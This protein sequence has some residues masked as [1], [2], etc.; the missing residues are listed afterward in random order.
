[1]LLT[2]RISPRLMDALMLLAGFD[3]QKTDEPKS[4][5]DPHNLFEAVYEDR[6]EGDFSDR[7][8]PRS[9]HNWL[10]TYPLVR[11]AALAGL[12]LGTVKLLQAWRS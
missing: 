4:E 11:R 8:H 3:S 12:A 10:E 5:D 9:L 1:M 6:I 7:A 2:Q